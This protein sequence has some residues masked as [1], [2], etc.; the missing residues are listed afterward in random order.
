MQPQAKLTNIIEGTIQ[1]L[2][3]AVHLYL[4]WIFFLFLPQGVKK[5][6]AIAVGVVYPFISSL[7]AIA[8]EELEDDTYWLTY[9]SCY[10]V[11]FLIIEV[12]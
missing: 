10:G 12:T 4:L 5:F 1:L 6:V 8:T 2:S 9:W 7:V 11:L 3:S